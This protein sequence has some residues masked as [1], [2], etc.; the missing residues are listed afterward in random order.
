MEV[1]KDVLMKVSKEVL[2]EV[3]KEVLMEGSKEVLTEGS[4]DILQEVSKEVI[5]LIQVNHVRSAIDFALW[6]TDASTAQL[7]NVFAIMYFRF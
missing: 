1:S 4:K 7:Q 3:S 6:L 2:M 5:V